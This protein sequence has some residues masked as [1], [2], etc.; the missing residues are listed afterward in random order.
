MKVYIYRESE[1]ECQLQFESG[2]LFYILNS[3]GVVHIRRVRSPYSH[4]VVRY[5]GI[6]TAEA[7][8]RF[9]G[10]KEELVLS[11][12]PLKEKPII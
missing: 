12:L 7:I 6:T 9:C 2:E 4:H 8:H 11:F 5:E 10:G 3:N 1:S